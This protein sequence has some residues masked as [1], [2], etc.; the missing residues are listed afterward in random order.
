[1]EKDYIFVKNA[2]EHNLQGIDLRIPRNAMVVFTGLSGSGKSSLAFDTI[3][4]EGQR[5]YVESLSAYAR[6]FLG[7]M[8]KPNVE[9]IE[10]LSPAISIEQRA[11]GSNPRSTV[12]TTTEIYD[13]L[14][15]L[16]AKIGVPHCH[17]C[18]R[19]ITRQSA[20]EVVEQILKAPA[21]SKIQILAPV[22]EGHKGEYQKIFKDIQKE[23]FV[24]V[25]V[26]GA[27]YEITDKIRLDRKK[28]HVIDIVVDRL[29]LKNGIKKRLTDSVESAL[30]VGKG[31]LK[32]A[33]EAGGKE[34]LFSELH[35]CVHCGISFQPLEPRLFSFNSPYGA[36]PGC[37]GLGNCLKID[38]DLVIPD[39]TKPVRSA[40][41]A[42]NKGG[43]SLVIYLRRLLRHL[44]ERHGFSLDTP[45][46]ELHKKHREI[47]LYGE[48]E[49]D[50]W[51]SFE[52][53]IPNLERRFKETE[54][55]YMKEEINKFMSS[56]PC[57]ECRGKRLKPEALSVR[58]QQKNIMEF[59]SFSI[60]AADHF[61]HRVK[62]TETEEKIAHQ[63]LKEVRARLRFM[64]NVGLGYLTLDRMS[65][66]LSGGEAQR[67]RLATQIG[68]GLMGVL[69]VL[70]EPSIGLHQRDN[71]K[72]LDALGAL[73]NLG[74]T[75]IVVEHDEATMMRAD[76]LVDLGP[77]AGKHG[78]RI[79]AAGTPQEVMKNPDSLTGRYLKRELHIKLPEER[80]DWRGRKKLII[81]KAAEHNLKNVDIEI[82]LGVFTCVTGVSGSGKSTLVD[83]I[84]YKGLAK[85]LYQSKQRPGRHEAI[86]G[87]SEVD[88]VIEID[89]SPIGRT[90]RSNPA[91][92][93]GLFG[94]IRDIFAKLPESRMRGYRPGRF[95]FNVKGGRCEACEGDG[96]KTIEMHFL[97]DIYVT[98]EVCRGRRFNEQ[99]L[100]VR[101]KGKS[102][103]EVLEMT[104]EE[105]LNLFS[106]L[107]M[108]SSKLQTLRDV[109]LDYVQ[110]GQPATTLSGGEAQRVKLSTELSKRATGRTFYIL[111]EPTTGLHFADI[112]RLLRVLQRLVD[113]GNTVLVIEHNLDVIKTADYIIDLGPEGGDQGGELVACGPPEDV[114]QNLRS[115]TGRFLK[116]VLP[117]VFSLFLAALTAGGAAA[118]EKS[119]KFLL[120]QSYLGLG[121]YEKAAETFEEAAKDNFSSPARAEALYWAA[122]TYFKSKDFPQ[123]IRFYSEVIEKYTS[124]RFYVYSKYSR[125]WA[126]F[127]LEEYEK[128][129]SE[130]EE[131]MDAFPEDPLAIEARY[132]IGQSY[133]ELKKYEASAKVL[134][135]FTEK[136]SL[137]PKQPN[138][139][140]LLGDCYYNLGEYPAAL[141]S[142]KKSIDLGGKN[143][144]R[145]YALHGIGWTYFQMGKYDES[146]QSFSPFDEELKDS[147][148]KDSLLYGRARSL[149]KLGRSEEALAPYNQVISQFPESELLPEV[150]F[151]KAEALYNLA[152][153]REA[154][155][156]YEEL[157]RRF[158]ASDLLDD[159]HYNLGWVYVALKD[160]ERA[161]EHFRIVEEDSHNEIL[162][163]GA[164]CRIG[165]TYLEKGELEKAL[166]EYD[167]VLKDS[168]KSFYSDYAQYQSATTLLRLGRVDSAILSF[169]GMLV[170]FQGSHFY[171]EA[172]YRLGNALMQKELFAEAAEQFK[173]L[174]NRFPESTLKEKAYFQIGLCHFGRQ[175][176]TQALSIFKNIYTRSP[177]TDLGRLCKYQIALCLIKLDKADQAIK[178][179]ESYL[180][181]YPDSD[182]AA[183]VLYGLGE[184]YFNRGQYT[185]ARSY[186]EQVPKK[187][188]TSLVADRAYFSTAMAYERDGDLWAGVRTFQGL[189][190]A[191]PKSE[192]ASKGLLKASE[193][194]ISQGKSDEAKTELMKI[195]SSAAPGLERTL[196]RKKLAEILK[197]QGYLK[198]AAFYFGEAL[199]DAQG[200]LACETSFE[201]AEAYEL[202]A[203]FEKAA[204]QFQN[205]SELY[206]A[207]MVYA[208]KA[209]LRAA[210]LFEDIHKY[211]EALKI[212]EAVASSRSNQ[213]DYAREKAVKIKGHL[214]GKNR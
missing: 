159:I 160:L 200:D 90:P 5:R 83:E 44:A 156:L 50:P 60:E 212:Y 149:S 103:S 187:F 114:A 34:Q 59:C 18:G 98:C 203:E 166:E 24:R 133:H 205:L 15:L 86:L 62:L 1:M 82:P 14:R 53:V 105:A 188:P 68:S 17:Q 129:I 79:V 48:G 99:T 192:W 142:F 69:Y 3:Y 202:Q 165:D 54:S 210:R 49:E 80:R 164:I 148:L 162:K 157:T 51:H 26:D 161:V 43:R 70:D 7:V 20:Q 52:G 33:S 2:R 46:K 104:V 22:V 141:E 181:E 186:F 92:Y 29:I 199:K 138:A 45:F 77:G 91:T 65:G 127:E 13:Y 207:N 88:K 180:S 167:K 55:E 76:Y 74:N 132:K 117:L 118:E 177:K 213:A 71:E 30:K 112:D 21:D 154:A 106:N 28:K 38:P 214:E 8:Q 11:A 56:H 172:L 100:E 124:S 121:D 75:L 208:D 163:V 136:Y 150:Y 191:F 93:T 6:Q 179:F 63:I 36:C 206:P 111:D 61:F 195:I 94:P 134:R 155:D 113:Q 146:L 139:H 78:G 153:Y 185:K 19:K 37:D 4:A 176:Y 32:V 123:S 196:A 66:S 184:Y 16:F 173:K 178:E 120:G 39:K 130:F 31:T 42:W 145:D 140:Y 40:I 209:R 168:P 211:K 57:Q 41:A 72:L 204:L 84:L 89:Q 193:F 102:I 25:R 137:N 152:R 128:A 198:E 115:H 135:G 189:A 201:L 110:L 12:G 158:P 194:M 197:A 143:E 174:M 96:V 67:I 97:P 119:E 27:V 73:R 125:A 109:G 10:G 35:A 182:R 122:E 108:V 64:K 58:V 47:V 131:L 169:Q 170:N 171:A 101:Y 175:D 85:R 126:Y 87:I 95:S 183:D 107:P 144:F 9:Y 151:W 23:G 190:Q 147:S 116:S 81:K